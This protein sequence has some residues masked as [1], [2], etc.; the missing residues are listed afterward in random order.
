MLASRGV[1]PE[2]I[3][4][5]GTSL[6]TGVAAEMARRG[7]GGRLVLVSPYTS[8]PDLVTDVVPFVPASL[9]PVS[10]THLD[11]YKRQ[12]EHTLGDA[13]AIHRRA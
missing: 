5:W 10:Y 7:R 3:V 6:G 13:Q 2:R 9:L 8:I 1:G 12:L 11:V 4:L